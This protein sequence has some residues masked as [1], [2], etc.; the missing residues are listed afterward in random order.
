MEF[1]PDAAKRN[2]FEDKYRTSPVSRRLARIIG[3]A[4]RKPNM[5]IGVNGEWGSGKSTTINFAITYLLAREKYKLGSDNDN[6]DERALTKLLQ[7]NDLS[8]AKLDGLEDFLASYESDEHRVQDGGTIIVRYNPWL[9]SGSEALVSDYFR[10]LG[11]TVSKHAPSNLAQEIKQVTSEFAN[12]LEKVTAAGKG[13]LWLGAI[14]A[15][16][17]LTGGIASATLGSLSLGLNKT[18][19][20]AKDLRQSLESVAKNE[21]LQSTKD[22]LVTTFE[23]LDHRLLVVMDDID[24]LENEEI[25]PFLSMVKAVGNIPNVTYLLGYDRGHVQAALTEGKVENGHHATFLEKIV[26]INIDL[27]NADPKL[28]FRDIQ[29]GL[30]EIIQRKLTEDEK[31]DMLDDYLFTSTFLER[32]RDVQKVLNAV[33]VVR[34]STGSELLIS[35]VLRMEFIRMK[36]PEAFEYLLQNDYLLNIYNAQHLVPTPSPEEA[37]EKIV[38]RVS[39]ERTHDTKRLLGKTFPELELVDA[40]LSP[41]Q[42]PA[43][44]GWPLSH[45]EGWAGYKNLFPHEDTLRQEIWLHLEEISSDFEKCITLLE[46]LTHLP[47]TDHGTMFGSMMEDA[48]RFISGKSNSPS[49]LLKA[50]FCIEDIFWQSGLRSFERSRT[51]TLVHLLKEIDKKDRATVLLESVEDKRSLLGPHGLMLGRLGQNQNFP[52]EIRER[53]KP[54]PIIDDEAF[55][56]YKENVLERVKQASNSELDVALEAADL[57]L[58]LAASNS[59]SDAKRLAQSLLSDEDTLRIG[60]LRRLVNPVSSSVGNYYERL[61]NI[62]PDIY[63]LEKLTKHAHKALLTPLSRDQELV[64]SG[65]LN[66]TKDSDS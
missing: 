39:T 11:E 2:P 7:E 35:D 40:L 57:L 9:V 13:A 17:G 63:P 58:M 46:G 55:S 47:R 59:K 36:E 60:I 52:K 26:Q 31:E 44:H 45:G 19:K 27:P 33:R 66:G 12:A 4:Q 54:V 49:G 53:D 14:A 50:V 29:I 8:D 32:P 56:A 10:V 65:F 20:A 64:I 30:E 6:D 23:N 28:L 62:D 48:P 41:K 51:T 15:D 3:F 18:N 37:I 5:V 16:L 22:K 42:Y 24:R 25:K 1:S 43:S 21:S 34:A 61:E 38:N